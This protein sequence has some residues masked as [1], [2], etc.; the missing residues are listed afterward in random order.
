MTAS[1]TVEQ[2]TD[3]VQAAIRAKAASELG[4]AEHFVSLNVTP[5]SVKLVLTIGYESEADAAA[6]QAALARK[7]SVASD[8]TSFLSTPAL[9][10]FVEAIDVAPI[11]LDEGTDPYTRCTDCLPSLITEVEGVIGIA[12]GVVLFGAVFVFVMKLR[13]ERADGKDSGM[14][15]RIEEGKSEA[16][17]SLVAVELT[18]CVAD[19]ALFVTSYNTGALGFSNDPSNIV[20]ILLAGMGGLSVVACVVLML[21]YMQHTKADDKSETAFTRIAP[22]I[23]VLSILFEDLFQLTIYLILTLSN[24]NVSTP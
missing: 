15:N 18:D 7:I 11:A 20:L 24:P 8:A 23:F 21:L 14:A 1:G 17:K 16:A 12:S 13:K 19:V 3:A 5:G 2:Y 9:Q 10:V 4:V 6:G 22:I